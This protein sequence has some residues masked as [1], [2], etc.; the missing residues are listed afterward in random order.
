MPWMFDMWVIMCL[1]MWYMPYKMV[2]QMK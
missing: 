1:E 2:T